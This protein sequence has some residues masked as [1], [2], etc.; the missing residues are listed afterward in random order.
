VLESGDVLV[1][2]GIVDAVADLRR[3]PGLEVAEKQ[4]GKLDLHNAQRR[5]VEL[6]V[7]PTAPFV[8]KSVKQAEFR[9]HYRAAI[10][11]IS[12]AGERL[13]GKV[14]DIVFAAG[15]TLLVE[16]ARD[17]ARRQR[18][19]RDFLLVSALDDSTPPD[20]RRAPLALAILVAMIVVS[21]AGLLSLLEAAFLAGGAMVGTRCVSL[22]AARRSIEYPV[23]IVI[24]ASFALGEAL[25]RS[26]AARDIAGWMVQLAASDPMM[27]LIMIYIATVAFTEVITNN[28]AAV[29][30]FPIAVASANSLG[31]APMPFLIA[32]MF[33]AS[34][35]F[36]TPIGYQTNLMVYGPGGY[37]F[38]DYFRFGLPL[39]ILVGLVTLSLVPRLWKF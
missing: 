13:S 31:V 23:L 12:R 24:A 33:A 29:L 1:C 2:I 11:S 6:V 22:D 16:A 35:S 26:G 18:Y 9:G 8:G 17:F 21:A 28:A 20:F 25:E 30:M 38:G 37:R 27:T 34:A 19:N 39:T 36:L 15:D 10:L 5:L 3:I 7:S 32:I 4:A 14:G